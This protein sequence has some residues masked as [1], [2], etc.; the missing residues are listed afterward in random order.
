MSSRPTPDA[1]LLLETRRAISRFFDVPAEKI[2]RDVHLVNDL[3]VEKLEPSFQCYV[4]TLVIASQSV[5]LKPF[6]FTMAGLESIDDLTEAIRKV[7]D[8]FDRKT[9]T[10]DEHQAQKPDRL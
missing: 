4:V 10:E 7:L 2:A 3:H 8:G 5:E 6:R 1:A 9:C